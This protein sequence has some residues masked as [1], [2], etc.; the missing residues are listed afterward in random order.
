MVVNSYAESFKALLE[1]VC[2]GLTIIAGKNYAADV[3]SYLREYVEKTD[4]VYIIGYAEISSYLVFLD[5][6]RIDDNDYLCVV[7]QL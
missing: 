1:G 7:F 2:R 3:K 4:N 5:I 6:I